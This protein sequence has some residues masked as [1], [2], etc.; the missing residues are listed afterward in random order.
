MAKT[1]WGWLEKFWKLLAGLG[2]L[3]ALLVGGFELNKIVREINA[4]PTP[5][6]ISTATNTPTATIAPTFTPGPFQFYDLPAQVKAG[7][8]VKV[9]VQAWQG[10]VCH[11]EYFTPDGAKSEAR[12]LGPATPDSRAR[13]NWEWHIRADT[14]PGVGRL[15]VSIDDLKEEHKIEILAGN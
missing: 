13:C 14:L 8:D 7:E 6:P 3:V 9:S 12:G 11:L 4:T 1:F 2:T 15:V 5:V 10:A